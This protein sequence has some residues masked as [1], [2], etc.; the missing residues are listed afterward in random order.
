MRNKNPLQNRGFLLYFLGLLLVNL[1]FI[2][3]AIVFVGRDQSQIA[4]IKSIFSIDTKYND[5]WDPMFRSLRVFYE[6]EDPTIYQ[7]IFF[8]Q[9]HKFQYPPT[10]LIFLDVF[11][12]VLNSFERTYILI[13]WI[14]WI[15]LWG[16]ILFSILIFFEAWRKYLPDDDSPRILKIGIGIVLTFS[17]LAFFPINRAFFLGQ[18]QICLDMLFAVSLWLWL[19][20]KNLGSSICLGLMSVIKPQMGLYAIW[21]FFRRQWKFCTGIIGVATL[22]IFVSL[23]RYG[24]PAHMKYLEVL[25]FIGKHG[26]SYY[27]NQSINGLM[28]RILFNGNNLE[29]DAWHFAPENTLV[30]VVT[31]ASSFLLIGFALFFNRRMSDEDGL[32]SFATAG[33]AFTIASPVA[34]EHHYGILFPIFALIFPKVWQVRSQWKQGFFLTSLAYLLTANIFLF[35]NNLASTYWNFLQSYLLFGALI[36]LGVLAK[37]QL[38]SKKEPANLIP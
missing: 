22:F 36:L 21:G 32:L 24:L 9:K 12:K 1:I 34:W 17:G 2:N 38:T 35:V 14:S 25:S 33:L 28:N 7:K 37:L 31:V 26:E 20:R 27:P 15:C 4:N 16:T 5:S 13:N 6:G 23:W 18:I 29:W 19:K 30:Q 3:G 11:R 8:N 10:S